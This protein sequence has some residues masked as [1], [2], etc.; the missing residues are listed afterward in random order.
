MAKKIIGNTVGV[1]NPQTDFK[2]SDPTKADYLKNSPVDTIEK[3]KRF[4]YYGDADIIPSDSSLFNYELNSDGQS[5]TIEKKD[6]PL[7][8]DIVVPYE[9]NGLPITEIKASAFQSCKNITSIIIPNSVT[10]IGV[11][12]FYKCESLNAVYYEG[13]EEEWNAISISDENDYLK[14]ANIHY[15]WT[16]A[17]KGELSNYVAKEDIGNIETKK[18]MFSNGDVITLDNNK[19][20]YAE[21][22]I[23]SLTINYPSGDFIASLEFTLASDGDITIMLPESKYIGGVPTFA[24]GEMWELNIKN[25][26]V[27]GG[28]IE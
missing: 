4:V 22:E 1:P 13:T 15:N 24:N 20:Y 7:S 14:S 9:Y 18:A 21:N 10:E 25:G 6:T 2:Q 8:F 11:N 23:S 27:V 3:M 26:V 28:L 17:M 5:Y 12:A 19:M 16:P